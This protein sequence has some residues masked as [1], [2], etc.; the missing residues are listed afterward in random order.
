MLKN[1]KFNLD[2]TLQDNIIWLNA[3]VTNHLCAG[4]RFQQ[5]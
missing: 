4:T 5:I 1:K 2:Q 3:A